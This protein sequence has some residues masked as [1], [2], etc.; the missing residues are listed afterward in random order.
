MQNNTNGIIG[1]WNGNLALCNDATTV[2][3]LQ[4]HNENDNMNMAK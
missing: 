4:G 3:E 2:K 1:G